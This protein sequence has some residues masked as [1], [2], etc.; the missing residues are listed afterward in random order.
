M[1]QI[2]NQFNYIIPL[3]IDKKTVFLFELF[4]TDYFYSGLWSVWL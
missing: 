1:W 2:A 4:W 3:E